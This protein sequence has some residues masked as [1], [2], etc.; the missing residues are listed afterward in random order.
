MCIL[1]GRLEPGK[2]T[3]FNASR[4]INGAS[5]VDYVII[6][7]CCYDMFYAM[8]VLDLTEFSDHCPVNFVMNISYLS[9][10]SEHVKFE[11]IIRNN[12]ANEIMLHDL[13][14]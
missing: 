2:F 9:D 8:N 13:K 4:N 7:Q 11:H 6:S 1:N 10:L 5:L 14:T 12:D 3:C